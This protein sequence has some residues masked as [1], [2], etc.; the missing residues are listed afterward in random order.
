MNEPG[1]IRGNAFVCKSVDWT[2]QALTHELIKEDTRL[3]KLESKRGNVNIY[4]MGH[5][6]EALNSVTEPKPTSMAELSTRISKAFCEGFGP[7]ERVLKAIHEY[8]YSP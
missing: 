1:K 7:R 6:L 3:C 8:Q 5:Y 4:R 2:I